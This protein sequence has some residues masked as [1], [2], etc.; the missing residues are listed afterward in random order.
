MLEGALHRYPTHYGISSILDPMSDVL[1]LVSSLSSSEYLIDTIRAS[2]LLSSTE[3][4]LRAK[5]IVP[6]VS[7]ALQFVAQARYGPAEVAF[8]PL[9]Y[10]MLNLAKVYVLLGARNA[11]LSKNRWH[12]AQYLGHAKDSHSL[13]TEEVVLKRSGALPL[14]YETLTGRRIAREVRLRLSDIYPF[15]ADVSAEYELVTRQHSKLAR[16]EFEI[17]PNP[18]RKK[19]VAGVVITPPAGP[20]LRRAGLKVIQ[21]GFKKH[22]SR[23]HVFVGP[24]LP[25]DATDFKTIRALFRPFLLY[26][27]ART[28]LTPLCSKNILLPEEFPII[29]AFFHLG[30]VVRYKPDFLARIRDSRFW[31]VVLAA[32]QHCFLKFVILFWSF[33]HQQSLILEHGSVS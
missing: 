25:P 9:Y 22:P 30:S 21:K 28:Y 31:P 12:G 6:H 7:T 10:A 32:Q 29:L 15:I 2:H 19:V 8:L 11:D 26:R 24:S 33:V 27:V 3:A 18:K 13:L 17:Q 14:F 1:A 23:P 5:T 4:R 16:I 20:V